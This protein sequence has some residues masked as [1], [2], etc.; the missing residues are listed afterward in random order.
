M[1]CLID[2]NSESDID[3]DGGEGDDVLNNIHQPT[4]Q[5]NDKTTYNVGEVILLLQQRIAKKFADSV[6]VTGEVT[7]YSDRGHLYLSLQSGG[8]ILNMVAWRSIAG[9]FPKIKT[10]D[11]VMVEGRPEI[12]AKAGRLNFIIRKLDV[13]VDKLGRVQQLMLQNERTCRTW[14][15]LDAPR[16]TIP[17]ICKKLVV[18][19]SIGGDAVCDILS[20]VRGNSLISEIIIMDCKV[21]G[22]LAAET[23]T[24]CF[25]H[26]NDLPGVD[27]ILLTRGGG[28]TDDLSCFNEISVLRAIFNSE[29]PVITAIG[30]KR[31]ISL[32]DRISDYNAITPTDA[33]KYLSQLGKSQVSE[34]LAHLTSSLE[35]AYHSKLTNFKR[36][37]TI[38]QTT[39][40]HYDPMNRLVL[41]E[42]HYARLQTSLI[43][44]VRNNV[45]SL[46]QQ[47]GT[48][49]LTTVQQ[50]D[51]YQQKLTESFYHLRTTITDRK[52][53]YTDQII[54]KTRQVYE[55]NLSILTD[56]GGY[57]LDVTKLPHDT[58]VEAVVINN[59]I[60]HRIT[61]LLTG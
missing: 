8:A 36:E 40:P 37:L 34:K 25:L 54:D 51:R 7:D 58:P 2:S 47:Y 18:I 19:T 50:L 53:S 4:I 23:I 49:S 57:T 28:S 5:T 35:T 56:T 1:A 16:Q 9:R 27:A 45:V 46:T 12:Y 60:H 11:T 30:H 24:R 10:G 41:F 55:G 52:M 44:R 29:Y 43:D 21:Q 32:A 22:K 42:K 20:V 14:G 15:A 38:R 33:G 59:G 61:V 13:K 48:K 6:I 26:A 17:R 31:D 39:L 3:S